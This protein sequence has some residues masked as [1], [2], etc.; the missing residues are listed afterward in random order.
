MKKLFTHNR[1]FLLILSGLCLSFPACHEHLPQVHYSVDHARKVADLTDGEKKTFNDEGDKV[2][3]AVFDD[4][5][6]CCR[7][8]ALQQRFKENWDSERCQEEYEKCM[9]T[10]GQ[11]PGYPG[12]CKVDF[13]IKTDDCDAAVGDVE[14]C[15]NDAVDSAEQ[16]YSHMS[17]T[18]SR[19][20]WEDGPTPPPSCSD[21][22]N[23]CSPIPH[24]DMKYED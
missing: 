1:L 19:E 9:S 6:M 2:L 18:H 21:L 7:T 4:K 13:E 15:F 17:C 20:K 14:A 3:N 16:F 5:D 11:T 12:K 24:V 10:Y 22:K 23:T 8:A